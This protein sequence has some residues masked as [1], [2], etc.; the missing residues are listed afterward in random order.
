M[1]QSVNEE[2]A[3][4]VLRAVDF[5]WTR[6][7]DSV[8]RNVN[9]HVEELHQGVEDS[10]MNEFARGFRD[11]EWSPVGRVL[12]GQ[13]GV[14]KTH[15]LGQMRQRVWH[16]GGWFILLD[17]V[18]VK[19]FWQST[20]LSFLAS[21]RR[22]MIADAA[23]YEVML[24]RLAEMLPLA[25][26]HLKV[27]AQLPSRPT[28]VSADLVR[29]F[30]GAL[31]QFQPEAMRHQDV[32]R[33]LLLLSSPDWSTTDLAYSWL[34]GQE[35]DETMARVLGFVQTHDT[36]S[37]I[38]R[39][40]C[41]IM[42][43]TAPALIAVDQIDA[44]VSEQ[45][46]RLDAGARS[47]AEAGEA[48]SIIHKLAGG[49]M[50]LHEV[51]GRAIT[52]VACLE[53]T[54]D[55]IK[56]KAIASAADRFSEPQLLKSIP[57]AEIANLLVRNR[58]ATAYETEGFKPPHP[59]WPFKPEAFAT[60]ITFK[61]RQ[62]LQRC[63]KHR[64]HCLADGQISE[65]TSFDAEDGGTI[66]LPTPPSNLDAQ[67]EHLKSAA[68]I[69]GLLDSQKEDQVFCDLLL[70]MLRVY[71][72]ETEMP[73]N[74]DLSI[75]ADFKQK[76]PVL[77][78]RLRFS[79]A[80]EGDR[81]RHFCFRALG[82]TNASAFQAR[83]RAAMTASGIDRALPF[84]KLFILR[85]AQTPGGTVTTK[86]VDE[87][88]K[89]GGQIIN[90]S[91]EDLKSFVA[92]QT[93]LHKA[94]D[95]LDDWLCSRKPLCKTTLFLEAGLCAPP[96]TTRTHEEATRKEP[97][98]EQEPKPGLAASAKPAGTQ[99]RG[100]SAAPGGAAAQ[101]I[102]IGHR[103]EGGK[104]R[105]LETL[106]AEILPRHTA[107]LA[108][109]GSGK[110]V[111]LRRIVEEA[112]LIG[113]PAIVLDTNNDL[114]RLGKPWPERPAAWSVED[115]A[116]AEEYRKRVEVVVWTPG[117]AKGNPLYLALLPDFAG[118]GDDEDEQDKA[119]QMASATLTPLVRG[120]GKT[121]GLQE[122]VLSSAMRYFA[123]SGGGILDDFIRLLADLPE[124]VTEITNAEKLGIDIA[125]QLRAAIEKNPLMKSRGPLL[126]P[127]TLFQASAKGKTR[128]SVI[129]F[130]GLASDDTRQAFVNQLQMALFAWIKKNPSSTGRLYVM[131]EAQNFAPSQKSTPCKESTQSLAAQA[132][133]Y[134]LG[135]I[136][137]TQTP[138]GIDN[139]IISNCTTHF[140]GKMSAPATLAAI[141]DM[142]A[143]RG[144]NVGDFGTLTRGQFYFSTEGLAKPVKINTP[145]CLSYHPANPLSEDE[146]IALAGYR[147][148]SN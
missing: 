85:R 69:A 105:R 56:N 84:R 114:A 102:P 92:L 110:T 135:M 65:L 42:G 8:W 12:M 43:L 66:P 145:L 118:V 3:F 140:Y 21:L 27:V 75:D 141:Q 94:P 76:T 86:I 80:A 107:I 115:S 33:A 90:P 50:D 127:S 146:V 62:L 123:R 91:D 38:V 101:A 139:K 103:I 120:A 63:D 143:A 112:A 32:L 28:G 129:N 147:T 83:L 48:L 1:D 82:H 4:S 23:Q 116:K 2:P 88:R 16:K 133:K 130:A 13:K 29:A 124:G 113:I 60:A 17:F 128:I 40:L 34:Q 142:A 49:L 71:V 78:G 97:T 26:E 20:A 98:R 126:D 35:T 100:S 106:P 131:D 104:E 125:N 89:A 19:D 47:E 39:G 37:Q 73:D 87:F 46:A 122:A 11:V 59:T 138:K 25:P 22:S 93:L 30:L 148:T 96:T 55:V 61:A 6:R 117:A 67:Y 81:E 44:I 72:R 137:A 77:H 54:W 74:V 70:D 119:I 31:H 57:S 51:K 108:S 14:G 111:I 132:R 136:F 18:D 109:A 134:G 79:Y 99:T 5:D 9:Y 52:L 10:L 95:G 144:G 53:A 36:P 24:K 7:L 15:L 121:K 68:E 41:W 58:L 64:N 45:N